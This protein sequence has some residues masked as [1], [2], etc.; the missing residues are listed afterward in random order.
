[1]ESYDN[2]KEIS[3]T[4]NDYEDAVT[5]ESEEDA[6]SLM[7]KM[8]NDWLEE[9]AYDESELLDKY[10]DQTDF[11]LKCG[12]ENNS[13][14]FYL[15]NDNCNLKIYT[16][17]LSLFEDYEVLSEFCWATYFISVVFCDKLMGEDNNILRDYDDY[18]EVL[19]AAIQEDLQKQEND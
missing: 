12:I 16:K 7:V 13:I 9:I 5:I 1:M 17:A 6:Y 2:S 11:L 8:F 19:C 15:E 4:T 10:K 3:L 18:P 14:T